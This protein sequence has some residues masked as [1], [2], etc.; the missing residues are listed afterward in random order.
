MH[1]VSALSVHGCSSSCHAVAGIRLLTFGIVFGPSCPLLSELCTGKC[2]RT[3]V[4]IACLESCSGLNISSRPQRHMQQHISW[5]NSTM[6]MILPPGRILQVVVFSCA[7]LPWSVRSW[8]RGVSRCAA[9]LSHPPL[10]TDES[11]L[12]IALACMT[13]A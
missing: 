11:P 5:I 2:A 8:L 6:Q 7:R 3:R 1:N 9:S 13:H 10:S 12:S 4:P